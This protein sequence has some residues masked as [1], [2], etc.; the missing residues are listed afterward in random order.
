MHALAAAMTCLQTTSDIN[1]VD[2]RAVTSKFTRL[3]SIQQVSIST[4]VSLTT[5]AAL[6]GTVATIRS[7]ATVLCRAGYTLGSVKQLYF[8]H[9][10][11]FVYFEYVIEKQSNV[12]NDALDI[13]K[14][15]L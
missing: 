9:A 5:F 11:L 6:L 13:V 12:A 14:I 1:L 10:A 2:F 3:N 4:G 8:Y 15:L 7:V